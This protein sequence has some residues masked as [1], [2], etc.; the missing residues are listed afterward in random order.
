VYEK[1][2]NSVSG[3]EEVV[4]RN[5]RN[6]I[7]ET[8]IANIVIGWDGELITPPLESGLLPGTFRQ[9]LLERGEIREGVIT[10][11]M[12]NQADEIYLINSVRKWRQA[13]LA[14]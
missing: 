9:Y 5:S 14:K 2:R 1:A 3:C 13:T 10:V 11:E 7:T 12:L 4:L 6:E 8:T